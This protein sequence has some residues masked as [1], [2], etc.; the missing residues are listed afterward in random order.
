MIPFIVKSKIGVSINKRIIELSAHFPHVL[1]CNV[2]T[3]IQINLDI[4]PIAN[5]GFE[6]REM[7]LHRTR[8]RRICVIVV[9][10]TP[11]VSPSDVSTVITPGTWTDPVILSLSLLKKQKLRHTKIF[12]GTGFAHNFKWNMCCMTSSY[13]KRFIAH[14]LFDATF[15]AS[16]ES[17]AHTQWRINL[18]DKIYSFPIT[19]SNSPSTEY[20]SYKSAII[21]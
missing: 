4:V 8:S 21:T 19:S 2:R 6:T 9:G 1:A 3:Y 12:I 5:T 20:D 13:N 10:A 18:L 11:V 17:L 15:E 16:L 14:L 7:L